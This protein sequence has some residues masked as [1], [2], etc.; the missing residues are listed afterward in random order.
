MEATGEPRDIWFVSTYGR[1]IASTEESEGRLSALE[2]SGERGTMPPLH[3]HRT[4]DELFHVIE[5]ELTAYVGDEVVRLDPGESAFAPRDISHTYRVESDGAHWLTV[6]APG[7]LERYFL[8]IGR[9]AESDGP[10]PEP[11]APDLDAVKRWSSRRA[12]RTAFASP[13]AA[14]WRTRPRSAS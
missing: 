2:V 6:G 7:G 8:A 4:D 13:T 11:V 14:C 5:G 3:V 1:V 10:P 9:P 12:R